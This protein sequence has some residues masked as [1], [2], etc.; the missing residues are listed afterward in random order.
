MQDI[1]SLPTS[2]R[3][4]L[5]Q[6]VTPYHEQSSETLVFIREAGKELARSAPDLAALLIAGQLGSDE[7]VVRETTTDTTGNEDC[8]KLFGLTFI[9]DGYKH[10]KTKTVERSY[11]LANNRTAQSPTIKTSGYRP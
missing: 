9:R 6:Q 4:H 10:T 5:Q 7:I 1:T 8:L 3:Q 2:V 11:R